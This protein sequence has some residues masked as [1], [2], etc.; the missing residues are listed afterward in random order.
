VAAGKFLIAPF[1][2]QGDERVRRPGWGLGKKPFDRRPGVLQ[3][4]R[5]HRRRDLGLRCKHAQAQ[6]TRYG[7]SEQEKVFHRNCP[8]SSATESY[9]GRLMV[10][11][12]IWPPV[13]LNNAAGRNRNFA[14]TSRVVLALLNPRRI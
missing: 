10:T 6:S 11:W 1:Q 9:H 13:G 3:G 8:R 5:L 7:A 14:V 2:A 12:P 4:L